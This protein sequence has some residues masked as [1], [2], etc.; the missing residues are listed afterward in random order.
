MRK[1]EENLKERG[2]GK[3]AYKDDVE[4]KKDDKEINGEEEEEEEKEEEAETSG[5]VAAAQRK[6]MTRSGAIWGTQIF[7]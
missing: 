4:A 6:Q 7:I 1:E 2:V 5:W 3:D